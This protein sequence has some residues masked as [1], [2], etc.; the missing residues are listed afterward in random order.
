MVFERLALVRQEATKI[1]WPSYREAMVSSAIVLSLMCIA[2]VVLWAADYCL[3][4][5]GRFLLAI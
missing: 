4:A 5:V 3:G 1:S 2:G